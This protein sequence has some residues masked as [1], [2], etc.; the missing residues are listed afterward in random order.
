MKSARI[1]VIGTVATLFAMGCAATQP[2]VARDD[3][4]I[5]NDVRARIAA[6]TT[7]TTSGIKVDTKNGVVQLTGSVPNDDMRNAAE[8]VAVATPGVRSVDNDVIFGAAPAVPV[9]N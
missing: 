9:K 3:T 5:T 1:A 6:D 4:T 7:L 8:R 2:I